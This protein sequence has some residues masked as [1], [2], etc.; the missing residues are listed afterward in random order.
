MD[1]GCHFPSGCVVNVGLVD[2][3]EFNAVSAQF[4]NELGLVVIVAREATQVLHNNVTNFRMS[5]TVREHALE[6][7]SLGG[8]RRV[9]GIGESAHHGIVFLMAEGATRLLLILQI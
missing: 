6:F 1:V 3:A 8:A 9:A 5:L 2:G 7:G 4:T